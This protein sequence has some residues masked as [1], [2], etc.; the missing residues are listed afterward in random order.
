MR[1]TNGFEMHITY[2][3]ALRLLFNFAIPPQLGQ[4]DLDIMAVERMLDDTYTSGTGYGQGARAS[5]GYSTGAGGYSNGYA[6][7]EC[8]SQ[9]S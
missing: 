3:A 6:R 7:N 9:A 2:P 1:A 5:T 8:D 4:K